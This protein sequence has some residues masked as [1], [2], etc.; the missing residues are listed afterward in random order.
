MNNHNGSTWPIGFLEVTSLVNI[1]HKFPHHLVAAPPPSLAF[2]CR[3]F[4]QGQGVTTIQYCVPIFLVNC[5]I[6]VSLG[7]VRCKKQYS[8]RE[9]LYVLAI[10]WQEIVVC[11][12]IT[13]MNFYYNCAYNNRL[14]FSIPSE[15]RL[16]DDDKRRRAKIYRICSHS[17]FK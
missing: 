16:K 5:Q 13:E 4:V 6:F 10:Y 3:Y 14:F 8:K 17:S 7:G 11:P 9:I 12:N 1:L 15:F 2:S